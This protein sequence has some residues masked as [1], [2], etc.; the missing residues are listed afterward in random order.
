[1]TKV[2]YLEVS[3]SHGENEIQAVLDTMRQDNFELFQVVPN[4]DDRRGNP[5]VTAGVY[6]FFKEARG[7]SNA[8]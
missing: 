5:S 8:V 6:L 3:G 7:L 1:M 2:K 4:I